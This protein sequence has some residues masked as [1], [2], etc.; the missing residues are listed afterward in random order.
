MVFALVVFVAGL[1]ARQVRRKGGLAA[2]RAN[3][4]VTRV[5]YQ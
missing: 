5:P 3:T 4:E 2:A 1:Q